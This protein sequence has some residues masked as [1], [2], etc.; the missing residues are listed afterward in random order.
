MGC[1]KSSLFCKKKDFVID[2][3][4]KLTTLSHAFESLSAKIEQM[5]SIT[6]KNLTTIHQRMALL[7]K[8]MDIEEKIAPFLQKP[9]CLKSAKK[10]QEIYEKTE[11]EIIKKSIKKEEK[12]ELLKGRIKKQKHSV[13]LEWAR[14][15]LKEEKIFGNLE[16]L[17]IK[18]EE[19]TDSTHLNLVESIKKEN[20]M[21]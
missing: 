5:E 16:S 18:K 21:E 6:S 8:L 11:G 7:E 14:K 1:I 17:I 13:K 3:N 2:L 10:I 19:N 4:E 9:H 20:K 12:N 15:N